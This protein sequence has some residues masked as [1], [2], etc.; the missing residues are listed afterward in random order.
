MQD[1]VVSLQ[2]GRT[3]APHAHLVRSRLLPAIQ[4]AR[5]VQRIRMVVA[6]LGLVRVAQGTVVLIMA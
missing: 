6:E 2:M 5:C 4:P 1:M 3:V